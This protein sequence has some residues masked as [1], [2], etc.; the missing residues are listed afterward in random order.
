MNSNKGK[1]VS[2]ILRV[3]DQTIVESAGLR[4]TKGSKARS[5]LP[6]RNE[7]TMTPHQTAQ[8]PSDLFCLADLKGEVIQVGQSWKQV[9]SWNEKE[10]VGKHLLDLIHPDDR[11]RVGTKL[12][13][14]VLEGES[15]SNFEARC[16]AKKGH[17]RWFLWNI[18]ISPEQEV[19]IVV[20]QDI[21]DILQR[22]SFAIDI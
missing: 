22:D 17:H 21:T 12:Q 7:M 3:P 14:L 13:K 20:A 10:V 11:E 18:V 5:I 9:L 1:S 2:D 4:T 19:M 15:F 6:L 8:N 16:L